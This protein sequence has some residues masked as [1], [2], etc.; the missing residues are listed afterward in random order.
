MDARKAIIILIIAIIIS[1]VAFFFFKNKALGNNIGLFGPL[2]IGGASFPLQQGSKGSKVSDIQ[3][4]LNKY[5]SAGLTVDSY[6]GPLTAAA[7]QSIIGTSIVSKDDYS[8]LM[9]I[10]TGYIVSG[11]FIRSDATYLSTDISIVEKGDKV[12]VL[13]SKNGFSFI[14]LAG[15]KY[16]GWIYSAQ[17]QLL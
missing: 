8:M 3:T 13:N 10:K 1:A 14:R 7:V 2:N 4:Q 9:N 6:Y 15:T 17:I 5:F 11:D 12:Y 16:Q